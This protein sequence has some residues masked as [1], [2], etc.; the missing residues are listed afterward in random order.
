MVNRFTA[1]LDSLF[2]FSKASWFNKSVPFNAQG[3][4][5]P[6]E[7]T[8]ICKKKKKKKERKKEVFSLLLTAQ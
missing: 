3:L 6:G 8:K 2:W 7:E 5:P 4:N 1:P